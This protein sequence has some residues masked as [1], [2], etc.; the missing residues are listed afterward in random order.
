MRRA[1]LPLVALLSSPDKQL[2]P[3]QIQKTLFLLNQ[4]IP[5]ALGGEVYHFTPYNYGPFDSAIYR[6]LETAIDSGLVDAIPSGGGWNEYR[7]TPRG[8]ARASETVQKLDP[9]ALNYIRS[10]TQW[11]RSVSFRELLTTVYDAY[12]DFASRSVFRR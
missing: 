3:I 11:V 12:P 6:D 2:T 4:N 9:N 7:I 5:H 8:E 1:E 10:L